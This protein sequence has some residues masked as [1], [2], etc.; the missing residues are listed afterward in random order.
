MPKD[1]TMP[2]EGLTT[3][4]R[5][6][7]GRLCTALAC[8]A[9]FAALPAD[10]QVRVGAFADAGRTAF[11]GVAPDGVKYG[12][13]AGFG[14]GATVDVRIA[15]NVSLSS[16]VVYVQRGSTL[17]LGESRDGEPLAELP[18]RVNY[19]GIPVGFA[20]WK[21]PWSV[22]SSVA[23]HFLASASAD[24]QDAAIDLQDAFEPWDCEAHIDVTREFGTGSRHW[25]AGLQYQVGLLDVW[26]QGP[27]A[28]TSVV[29]PQFKNSGIALRLGV[30]FGL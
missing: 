7:R 28:G 21:G 15:T 30:L 25:F 23:F 22:G 17:Q 10:A 5:N 12:A 18:V 14:A 19:V 8:A 27:I 6:G 26:K 2:R 13:R 29:V 16:G 3:P 20:I 9:W 11:G 24:W 4:G 1:E